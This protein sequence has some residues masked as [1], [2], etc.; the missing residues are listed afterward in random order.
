MGQDTRVHGT[1]GTTNMNSITAGSGVLKSRLV[2]NTRLRGQGALRCGASAVRRALALALALALPHHQLA[3]RTQLLLHL[4]LPTVRAGERV[5]S[6]HVTSR[7]ARGRE[8]A[9]GG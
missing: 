1:T 5:T 8:A 7:H 4:R 2:L 3:Q 9:A 6:R